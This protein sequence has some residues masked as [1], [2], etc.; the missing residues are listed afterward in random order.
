M[1]RLPL[2]TIE[3]TVN[4]YQYL[5]EA[6]PLFGMDFFADDFE[7][8]EVV[9]L[10]D[11]KGAS[12]GIPIHF[13]YYALFLRLQGEAKRTINQFKY[14]IKPQSLQL[15]SPGSIYAFEDIS[16]ASKTYV[17]LF[18]KT[19]IEEDNLA[20]ELQQ[21]LF[22]FH[23]KCQKDVRLENRQYAE[24]LHLYEQL[25]MELRAKKEDYR[26]VV[27]MLINQLLILLKREKLNSGIKQYHTR[28]EQIC[29]E[30]LVLIEEH[31]LEERSVKKYASMLGISAKHLSETVQSTLHH[32]ARS[33]IY[34]RVIKESQY[35]LCFS[36]MSI[37]QIA[38]VLHFDTLSQFGRFFKRAEGLSPKVYRLKYRDRMLKMN[39][40]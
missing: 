11:G 2:F 28:A 1:K 4:T 32:T 25:S 18:D 8:K 6:D 24:A 27:K 7:A 33:Y 12:A 36:E 3:Q 9:L 19:F 14:E 40:K 10:E 34:E 15:V 22:D 17:L 13:N 38:Y 30:Y 23:R 39:E 26:T 35:L 21:A 31:Y 29:A 5:F 37:K 20:S 16:E